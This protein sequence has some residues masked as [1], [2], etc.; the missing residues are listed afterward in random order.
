MEKP[1]PSSEAETGYNQIGHLQVP[2]GAP[3]HLVSKRQLQAA[4]NSMMFRV[5]QVVAGSPPLGELG[6]DSFSALGDTKYLCSPKST[7]YVSELK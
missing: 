1:P 2:L 5:R 4:K 7:T 3:L 6:G